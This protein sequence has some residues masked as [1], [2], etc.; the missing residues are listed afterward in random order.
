MATPLRWLLGIV[1][2]V[3]CGLGTAW[4]TRTFI[5]ASQSEPRSEEP[6]AARVGVTSPETATVEDSF[7]ATGT[8]LALRSIELRPLAAGRVAEV[9]VSSGEEVT[10]GDIIFRLDTRAA[11]A[12]LA[13]ARATLK[14][15]RAEFRRFEE[16]EDQNVAAEARLEEARG[17]FRRA[18]AAVALANADLEDRSLIA[19]F[20]GVVGIIDIDPGEY[21][22]PASSVSTLEKIS[23]VVA[24]FA[25]PER[26]FDRAALGQ[27]VRLVTPAYP[28]RT[29]E[30]EV[31][32]ISPIISAA[33]R[34]FKVRVGVP[35]EDRALAPGMFVS[36]ELIFNS[37]EAPTLPDNAI[38]SEG[39]ATFVYVV[40]D[41][42]ARRTAITVGPS[43]GG[44]TEITSQIAADA[45]VIVTGW[46]TLSDG[47]P[48]EIAEGEPSE[49][50]LN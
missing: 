50:A 14:E 8:I 4:T 9:A 18:E 10:E 25:L 35:N 13:D 24:E 1:V 38:I 30:G 33:S 2:I 31:T 39:T 40:D 27:T 6:S 42:A 5:L 49:E 16:L 20:S 28:E 29:F 45:R 44:R 15:T 21:V 41:G 3:A 11:E 23:S 46:G 36:A 17:A 43:A 7:T 32:V 12:A 34:S 48:V 26:Y 19:P 22:D 37:Y 47:D